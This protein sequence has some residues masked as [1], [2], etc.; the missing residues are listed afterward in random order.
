MH[1][2]NLYKLKY[3]ETCEIFRPPRSSHCETCDNCVLKFDHHCMWLGTCIGKRNYH[4]FYAFL[5]TLW[6][7]I[8]F[9]IVLA[10][11]NLILYLGLQETK[12]EA[13]ASIGSAQTN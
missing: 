13:A 2:T 6:T 12:S 10:I 5:L 3:C 4:Y 11:H 9:T 1:G 8:I 7:E